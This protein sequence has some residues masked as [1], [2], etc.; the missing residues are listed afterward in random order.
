[1]VKVCV[2]GFGHIGYLVTRA[3]F[4]ASGKVDIVATYNLFIDLNYMVYMFQYDSIHGKFNVTVKTENGKLASKGPLK[5]ILGYTEDQVF[6]CNFISN[7]HSSTFVAGTGIAFNDYFVKLISWYDN[8]YGYSNQ[9]V[10]V[11]A[12]MASKE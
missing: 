5:G 8:E 4:S 3:T 12:Y 6:S 2:N 11:M 10:D 7:S 9:V 1:M